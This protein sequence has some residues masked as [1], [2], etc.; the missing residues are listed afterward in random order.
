MNVMSVGRVCYK[1][2]GR[3]AG[4]RVVVVGDAKSNEVI[5][6][7]GKSVQKCNIRHLFP[8]KQTESVQE[9]S[10]SDLTDLKKE[11]EKTE[12]SAKKKYSKEK[13]EKSD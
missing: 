8:T 12:K 6:K 7:D 10:L 9:I 11:K 1:T 3:N 4:N 5:I 13:K 2:K